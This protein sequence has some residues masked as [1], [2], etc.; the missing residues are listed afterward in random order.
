MRAYG[1]TFNN[2]RVALIG[3]NSKLHGATIY[4]A[5]TDFPLR[6]TGA[7]VSEI[8][9][10]VSIDEADPNAAQCIISGS[11]N[12]MVDNLTTQGRAEIWIEDSHYVTVQNCNLNHGTGKDDA[13]AIKCREADT[14]DITVT[15]CTIN[16]AESM[17]AFGGEVADDCEIYNVTIA[18]C[19]GNDVNFILSFKPGDEEGDYSGTVRDVTINNITVDSDVL[20]IGVRL[21]ANQDAILQ[22]V[23]IDGVYITGQGVDE[24]SYV[25]RVSPIGDTHGPG[26]PTIQ[27]V[28]IDNLH[29]ADS[30]GSGHPMQFGVFSAIQAAGVIDDIIIDA[31]LTGCLTDVHIIDGDVTVTLH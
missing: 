4:A 3:N 22:D 5:S 29:F 2:A 9:D 21:Q 6:I 13:I 24:S 17:F 1:A 20:E 10:V 30:G 31:W 7:N 19:V 18:D 27:R 14:H 16:G 11:A 25:V 26:M 8:K 12:V 15:N 23:S 28:T